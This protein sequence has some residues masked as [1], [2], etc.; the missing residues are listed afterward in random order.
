MLVPPP[1]SDQAVSLLSLP[2]E[3][4]VSEVPPTPV[5]FGSLAGDSTWSGPVVSGFVDPLPGVE[6]PS[7][8]EAKTV[9]PALANKAKYWSSVST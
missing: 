7:P 9:T 1:L 6:A 8:E 4:S 2:L 3:F 5:T